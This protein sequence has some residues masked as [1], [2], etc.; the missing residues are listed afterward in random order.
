MQ[1]TILD[2]KDGYEKYSLNQT[3]FTKKVFMFFWKPVRM[4]VYEDIKNLFTS[5]NKELNIESIGMLEEPKFIGFG[6]VGL[7]D[8]AG[9]TAIS[10]DFIAYKMVGAYTQFKPAWMKIMKDYPKLKEG[11][12][13]YKTDPTKTKE[14]E[15]ITYILVR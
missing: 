11:Y 3:F 15:N 10:G 1:T 5:Q 2:I 9:N 4:S 14:E 12:H 8:P 7:A 6:R 13:L